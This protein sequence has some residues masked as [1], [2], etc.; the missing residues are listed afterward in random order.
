MILVTGASGT[1]GREVVR[2]LVAAGAKFRAGYSSEEKARKARTGVVETVVADFASADSLRVA[3]K[4]CD[5]LFLL[6]GGQRD[7]ADLESNAVRA[8]EAAGIK[9]VVKL[10][11]WGAE[12]EEFSFARLHRPVEQLIE[13]TDL[14]WTFLRPNGFMQNVVNFYAETI[15]TQSAIYQPAASASVSHVD[16]RDVAAVAVKALT[17]P[18]YMGKAYTLS[19]PEAL[20]HAQLAEK[21]SAYL[22]RK[23]SYVPVSDG[24][25]RQAMIVSGIPDWYAD[26]VLDLTHYY[27]AGK[28]ARVTPTVREVLGRE[29]GSFDNFLKDSGRAL[30]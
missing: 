28:A 30:R 22:G 10:S 27:V 6:S 9:H 24:A 1:V 19:G 29:A 2:G 26:W 11:V 15:R 8:A 25:A 16:V 23:V 21:I 13:S 14:G 3:M 17:E 4:G 18:G 20:T 5:H 12:G 7:Q